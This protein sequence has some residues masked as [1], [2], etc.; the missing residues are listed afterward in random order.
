MEEN[1]CTGSRRAESYPAF[2]SQP[3]STNKREIC[4][5][6]TEERESVRR[7]QIS[8]STK[9]SITA[10]LYSLQGE[11]EK[12]GKVIQEYFDLSHAEIVPAEDL[13]KPHSE[14]FY[15][16]MHAVHKESSTTTKIRA[17]FNASLKTTSGISL[18]DTLMVGPYCASPFD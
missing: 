9:I 8:R 13:N 7:V 15:L 4:S 5:A 1:P 17:I 18:N 14:V 3:F 10:T 11:F 16:P 2:Q 12:F 6:S